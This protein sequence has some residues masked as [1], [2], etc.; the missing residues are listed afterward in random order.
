MKYA[1]SACLM[2]VNCKYNGGNNFNAQLM[3]WMKDHDYILICPEVSGGMSTPRIPSERKQ[4]Q[5]VNQKGEDVTSYF[6]KGASIE[7]EK[8]KEAQCDCV[9]V[10]SRSP[11]CG[12]SLIYDGSF[13]KKLIPGNGVFVQKCLDNGIKVV[14]IEEF[15]TKNGKNDKKS[16]YN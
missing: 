3:E 12:K 14:D 5:V 1:I 2:G 9:I 16:H 10:Q 15:L 13:T 4:N 11:S 6:E 7:L 8:I